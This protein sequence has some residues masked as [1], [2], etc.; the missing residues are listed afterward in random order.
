MSDDSIELLGVSSGGDVSGHDTA[1]SSMPDDDDG[2]YINNNKVIVIRNSVTGK[3]VVVDNHKKFCASMRKKIFAWADVVDRRSEELGK[4]YVL[5]ELS[6][7]DN[8][9]WVSKGITKYIQDVLGEVGKENVF[10]YAWVFEIKPVG[11]NL[12]YHLAM[13]VRPSVFVSTPDRSGM[14]GY[15]S[16]HIYRGKSS[17]YYLCKYV[18]K[19][20]QKMGVEFPK[21]SHKYHTWLNRDYFSEVDLWD[22]RKV[23]YPLSVRRFVDEM[24]WVNPRVRRNPGGGWL[25]KPQLEKLGEDEFTQHV[26]W[27]D[28]LRIGECDMPQEDWDNLLRACREKKEGV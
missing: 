26:V 13:L 19:L 25:V 12:H 24:G 27:S 21:G 3:V 1:V 5:I 15:G 4:T 6:Y 9:D 11:R 28:W 18:G 20:E 23:G 2:I 14:W 17:P 16:S 22:E 10:A 8:D 7:A